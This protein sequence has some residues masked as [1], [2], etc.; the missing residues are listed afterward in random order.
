MFENLF[1]KKE[2]II[3]LEEGEKLAKKVIEKELSRTIDRPSMHNAFKKAREENES[4]KLGL[5]NNHLLNIIKESALGMSGDI[6]DMMYGG[7]EQTA[8]L[9]NAEITNLRESLTDE[10]RSS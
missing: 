5:T 2:K 4:K 1:S 9:I 3:S 8:A 7:P 10:E 6:E